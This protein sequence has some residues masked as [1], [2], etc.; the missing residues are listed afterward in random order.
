MNNQKLQNF[1]DLVTFDQNLIALEFSIISSE[2]KLQKLHSDL[3]KIQYKIEEKKAEKKEL[4]KNFDLHE[5][6]L[7]DLHDKESH[8]I[9]VMQRSKKGKELDAAQKELEHIRAERAHGEKKLIQLHNAYQAIQKEVERLHAEYEQKTSSISNEI[10][11]EQEGLKKL[12]LDI[13]FQKT[14]RIAKTAQLPEEWILF[15][16][17]MRGKVPNPVVAVSQD[18][19]SACFYLVSSKDLQALRQNGLVPCKDC[20]R[21]LY[22][23]TEATN[24]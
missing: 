2:K 13:E 14:Q 24:K 6:H 1:I 7:K 21:F 8:H 17:N 16:E 3:Q 5:L 10:V 23:D 18:S 11:Q 4:K 19:C 20:Y 12:S 9:T 15:Y 22:F